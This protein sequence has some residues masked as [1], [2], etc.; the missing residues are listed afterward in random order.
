MVVSNG[1]DQKSNVA[2]RLYTKPVP[3]GT[4]YDGT[5][6][7]GAFAPLD[8]ARRVKGLHDELDHDARELPTAALTLGVR[9]DS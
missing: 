5:E 6:G 1:N 3:Y 8:L 2:S 7:E 4:V 9:P